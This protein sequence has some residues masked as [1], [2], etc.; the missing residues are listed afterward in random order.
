MTNKAASHNLARGYDDAA[1]IPLRKSP[2]NPP[3]RDQVQTL[4]LSLSSHSVLPT[5]AFTAVYHVYSL[6]IKSFIKLYAHNVISNNDIC[7][8][9]SH[10][11]CLHLCITTIISRLGLQRWTRRLDECLLYAFSTSRFESSDRRYLSLLVTYLLHCYWRSILVRYTT[12]LLSLQ[13]LFLICEG[14]VVVYHPPTACAPPITVSDV[15]LGV[16]PALP[17]QQ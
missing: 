6:A 15:V 5:F 4:A 1:H 17:H 7:D 8:T 12:P 11:R 10:L 2:G 13:R 14:T 9:T 16:K 3:Y